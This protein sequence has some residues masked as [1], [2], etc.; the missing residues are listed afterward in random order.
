[1]ARSA[2]QQA[3]LRKAQLASAA[4]R[5]GK[6]QSLSA[7]VKR[8]NQE[9]PPKLKNGKRIGEGLVDTTSVP[10][11]GFTNKTERAKKL[12]A[13]LDRAIAATPDYVKQNDARKAAQRST[14]APVSGRKV[15][16]ATNTSGQTV[17][18]GNK[19][20]AKAIQQGYYQW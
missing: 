5:R 19:M 3:A 2:K 9:G 7:Q 8:I 17:Y 16:A 20:H 14:N 10:K 18:T 12:I 15:Y 1:M 11:S 4:K 6:G 13:H